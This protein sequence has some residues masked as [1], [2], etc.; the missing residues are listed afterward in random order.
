MEEIRK[1]LFKNM[2]HNKTILDKLTEAS[3]MIERLFSLYNK[4]INLLPKQW[5]Y[6]RG[7]SLSKFSKVD[8]ARVIVDYISGMTDIFLKKEYLKFYKEEK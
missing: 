1:F 4:D 7:V 8:K 5:R 6:L 3:L 2:Y